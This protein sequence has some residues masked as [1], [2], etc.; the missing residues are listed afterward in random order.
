LPRQFCPAYIINTR[1]YDFREGQVLVLSAPLLPRCCASSCRFRF[2]LLNFDW[3]GIDD[4]NTYNTL[5]AAWNAGVRYYDVSPW[6]YT[7]C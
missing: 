5:E 6:S 7:R 4:S 3:F 1:G 2:L